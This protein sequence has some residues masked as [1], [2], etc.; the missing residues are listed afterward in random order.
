M[1]ARRADCP[2]C[3]VRTPRAASFC[4]SCGT[5]LDAGATK[6]Q[7]VPPH[8]TSSS[9]VAV[10]RTSPRWFGVTPP[11]LLFGLSIGALALALVLVA[12]GRW[13]VGLLVLGLALL[14]FAAF[15]EV[16]RRKPDAEVVKRAAG[17]A[18]SVRARAGY[19]AHALRT[20]SSVRRELARRRAELMQLSSERERLLRDLGAAA[21]AGEDDS[22]LRERIAAIDTR[23]AEV[24]A[25]A[26][27]LVQQAQA[28]VER[29]ALAVQ[30]TE[31]SR[32]ESPD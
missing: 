26:R 1:P 7:E 12:S 11:T 29:A 13:V 16:A 32:R 14:L 25:E 28:D 5:A 24:D 18:D 4:P 17:A 21:Y 10:A 22:P 27:T 30:P 15:L 20:R 19:A 31:V 9:P 6:P 3:G 8:E 2:A 23:V